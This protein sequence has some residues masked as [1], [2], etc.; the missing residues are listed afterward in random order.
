MVTI[1][2]PSTRC[3]GK[4]SQCPAFDIKQNPAGRSPEDHQVQTHTY[5]SS[6]NAQS[7]FHAPFFCPHMLWFECMLQH[8]FIGLLNQAWCLG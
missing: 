6:N 8:A 4:Y 3:R 1:L 5:L 7:C 2:S